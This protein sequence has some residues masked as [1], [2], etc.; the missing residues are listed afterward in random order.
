MMVDFQENR[1]HILIK[2][3]GLHTTEVFL[4]NRCHIYIKKSLYRIQRQLFTKQL[5]Y[6]I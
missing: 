3:I 4:K 2:K 5:S 1:C 6:V